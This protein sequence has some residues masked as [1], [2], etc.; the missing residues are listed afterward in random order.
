MKPVLTNCAVVR[1]V[2]LVFQGKE[3]PLVIVVHWSPNDPSTEFFHSISENTQGKQYNAMQSN[4]CWI[5]THSHR[6]LYTVVSWTPTHVHAHAPFLK[7][8]NAIQCN[9]IQCLLNTHTFTQ[10]SIHCCLVNTNTRTRTYSISEN[11]Q[12]NAIQCNACW[13]HTYSYRHIHSD[14]NTNACT[15]NQSLTNSNNN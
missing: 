13:M 14:M 2:I 11:T 1:V 9:A 12:C 5:H 15:Y 6:H 3:C 7:T 4:A 10:A 8:H